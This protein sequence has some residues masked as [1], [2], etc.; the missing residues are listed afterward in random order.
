MR[1]KRKKSRRGDSGM[2]IKVIVLSLLVHLL[3][4]A[5]FP[6]SLIFSP[7]PQYVE[8]DLLEPESG[9]EQAREHEE[10]EVKPKLIE[11]GAYLFNTELRTITKGDDVIKLTPKEALGRQTH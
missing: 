2:L 10:T 3:M 1:G 5:L 7:P 9:I 4:I 11:L 8:V 6:S